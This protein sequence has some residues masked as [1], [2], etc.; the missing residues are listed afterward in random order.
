MVVSWLLLMVTTSADTLAAAPSKRN[1]GHKHFQSYFMCYPRCE[2]LFVVTTVI[3]EEIQRQCGADGNEKVGG[4]EPPLGQY[5]RDDLETGIK[6]NFRAFAV[7]TLSST[8]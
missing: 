7:A 1:V 2:C 5:E 8:G 3:Y 6:A 4:I